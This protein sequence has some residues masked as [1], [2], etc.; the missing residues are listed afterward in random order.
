MPPTG[1]IKPHAPSKAGA[2]AHTSWENHMNDH[3]AT[4]PVNYTARALQQM[5]TASNNLHQAGEWNASKFLNVL[6]NSI[7]FYGLQN[8]G[9]VERAL[10]DYFDAVE[11]RLQ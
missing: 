9:Q 7:D 2:A 6:A 1:G 11:Q 4:P 5:R 3:T 10:T 8:R